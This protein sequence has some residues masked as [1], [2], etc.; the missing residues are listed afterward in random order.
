[1][2]TTAS[3]HCGATKITLPAAP[4]EANSCNCTYCARAAALWS[5]YPPEQLDIQAGDD[6]SY[7]ATGL[8]HHHF[9]GTCGMQ[10]HGFSPDWGSIYN[11]D[12]SPKDGV[13]PGSVPTGQKA[14]VNVRMI[15]D[16]DESRLTIAHMDGRNNW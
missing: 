3:C 10:T 14:M 4:T 15:D 13:E 9:C 12:G 6:R 16:L 5:Y 2:T 11:A 7:S 1:M 8:N